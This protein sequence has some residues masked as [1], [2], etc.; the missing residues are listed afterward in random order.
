MVATPKMVDFASEP[1][2]VLGLS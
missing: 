2:V 1:A